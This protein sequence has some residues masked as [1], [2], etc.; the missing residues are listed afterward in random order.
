MIL[1]TLLVKVFKCETTSFHYL[2]IL[3][4]QLQEMGAKKCLNNTS[5]VSRRT[6]RQTD[7]RT[8]ISTHRK[9]RPRGTML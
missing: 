9:H 6:D 2:Q 4:N 3:D 1:H 7:T 8:N 5:K